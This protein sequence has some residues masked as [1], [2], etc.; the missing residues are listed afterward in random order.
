MA[1]GTVIEYCGGLPTYTP[2]AS[3]SPRW[4]LDDVG[5]TFPGPPVDP[6]EGQPRRA[7]RAGAFF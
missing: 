5:R 4:P 3:L 1:G 6:S 2:R 7:L